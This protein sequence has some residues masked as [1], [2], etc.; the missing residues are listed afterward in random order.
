MDGKNR[1]YEKPRLFFQGFDLQGNRFI[2]I[3]N[4]TGDSSKWNN[5]KVV[6][7]KIEIKNIHI[8][9][10]VIYKK[11]AGRYFLILMGSLAV[12]YNGVFYITDVGAEILKRI[13][14]GKNECEIVKELTEIYDIEKDTL[15]KDMELFICCLK[16]ND[17]VCESEF[18]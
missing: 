10:E 7:Q 11:I 4:V 16:S 2:E 13:I 18:M 3:C 9:N 15:Q 1:I 17:L 14:A 8:S 12:R 5:E 6:F